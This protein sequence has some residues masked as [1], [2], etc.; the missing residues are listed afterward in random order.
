MQLFAPDFFL[1]IA[2]KPRELWI[3]VGNGIV[4]LQDG[5]GF[6][7]A[8]KELFQVGLL[9]L[10]VLRLMRFSRVRN[11]R[12]GKANGHGSVL[13]QSSLAVFPDTSS[14]FS[15]VGDLFTHECPPRARSRSNVRASGT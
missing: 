11:A 9:D 1:C 13:V 14:L 2:K 10:Q 12:I 4:H 15:G 6:R 3:D 8:F 7:G 5:N